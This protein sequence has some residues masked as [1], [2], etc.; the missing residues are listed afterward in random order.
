MKIFN[1]DIEDVKIVQPKSYIDDRG[2][3]MET[4]NQ[5]SFNE[6]IGMEVDFVQDNFS[7][8]NFGVIR[9]LHY[10][11]EKPQ[12]KLVRVHYGSVLDV[13]VDIRKSSRTFG[14]YISIELNDKNNYQLWIPEGFAH[15]FQV[16]SKV[17]HFSYKVTDY[18]DPNDQH[19]IIW[20]DES[21]KI[22]WKESSSNV[23]LSKNDSDGKSIQEAEIFD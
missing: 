8:S 15:G 20:N 19:C 6:H 3:F 10:Q 16:L 11:L 1:T 4:W 7:I 21:I 22:N 14:K 5:A 9:G 13:A 12:G 18:F 2:L 23:V 17:A